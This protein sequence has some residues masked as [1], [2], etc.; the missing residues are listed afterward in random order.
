[1]SKNLNRLAESLV[2]GKWM[3]SPSGY[4]MLN[5]LVKKAMNGMP[6]PMGEYKINE[7]N[8][9]SVDAQDSNENNLLGVLH[10]NGPLAKNISEEDVELGILSV[11]QISMCL[12]AMA[13]DDSISNI[14]LVFNSP[15]GE[16][17][18]I[19]ELGRKIADIDTVKPVYA[20]TSTQA[21]SAAYW[22]ASQCRKIGMTPSAT[23]GN[24]GVYSL[25][26][27]ETVSM[28]NSGVEIVPI[29]SGKYKLIGHSFHKLTDEEKNIIQTDVNNQHTKFKQTILSKRP[30]V[31]EDAM[32]GLSYE[33]Q[34]ALDKKLA[35][36]VCDDF[37]KFLQSI[38]M[39][40]EK[41][42]LNSKANSQGKSLSEMAKETMLVKQAAV[43]GVPGTEQEE[44]VP[45]K[46][47]GKYDGSYGEEGSYDGS[48]CED[49]TCPSCNNKFKY[50][51]KK[52]DVPIDKQPSDPKQVKDPS[53]TDT[54][55]DPAPVD[56]NAPRLPESHP[57]AEDGTV[58][59][60]SPELNPTPEDRNKPKLPFGSPYAI[61]A[62]DLTS[63][64][65]LNAIGY[66]VSKNENPFQ[67]AVANSNLGKF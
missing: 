45:K 66:K 6:A 26:L 16:T 29:S 15:G 65:W 23:V 62:E 20:W 56:R 67:S 25:V 39:K 11:D 14:V 3:I 4:H 50:T 12:D 24:I 58:D 49:V 22:L 35:D 34:A 13:N 7:S 32:E 40:T 8:D 57:Y 31:A 5:E 33:G 47:D 2:N 38:D 21:S 18:G 17:V 30:N 52:S 48:Y 41:I 63:E 27:D 61:K 55:L 42:N 28:K 44:V 9:F 37:D 54:T 43:P 19:E 1:M 64:N 36:I 53:G 59:P 10:I 60:T 51:F 46:A